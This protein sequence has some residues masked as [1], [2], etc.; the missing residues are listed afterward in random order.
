M[1][2]PLIAPTLVTIQAAEVEDVVGRLGDDRFGRGNLVL[3]DR[4]R[5][6]IQHDASVDID[7]LEIDL[8]IHRGHSC[9]VVGWLAESA[10]SFV[11]E[12]LHC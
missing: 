12:L 2:V 8:S 11:D 1:I 5:N 4:T 6:S 7:P 3:A 10:R 9:V